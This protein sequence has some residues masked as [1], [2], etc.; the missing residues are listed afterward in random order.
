MLW[1]TPMRRTTRAKTALVGGMR[2]NETIENKIYEQSSKW[3]NVQ[4]WYTIQ[5]YKKKQ[6]G[7]TCP[8]LLI[9]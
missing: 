6:S 5:I 9:V 4:T 8:R 1:V 2:F 3:E 7:N